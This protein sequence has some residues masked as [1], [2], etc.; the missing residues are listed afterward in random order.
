MRVAL[1][2]R[3]RI[4]TRV[5]EQPGVAIWTFRHRTDLD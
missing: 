4:D 2:G 1:K 5:T 3:W